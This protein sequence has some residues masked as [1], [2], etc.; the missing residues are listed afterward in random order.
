MISFPCPICGQN[1]SVDNALAGNHIDCDQCGEKSIIVPPQSRPAS[2]PTAPKASKPKPE[3]RKSRK[4]RFADLLAVVLVAIGIFVCLFALAKSTTVET[5]L[6][7]VHNIGLIHERQTRLMVGLALIVFGII[8]A[9]A[10]GVDWGKRDR[11]AANKSG[12]SVADEIEKLSA[13]RE[14]GVLSSNEFEQRKR[15]L[16]SE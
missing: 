9:V 4:S 16:L 14:K 8:M 7:P 2:Y 6:G 13:L 3:K 12:Y 11:I 1:H 15:Q 5:D 10:W